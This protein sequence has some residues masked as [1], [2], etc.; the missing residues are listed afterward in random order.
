MN[1]TALFYIS[2]QT[3]ESLGREGIFTPACLT[4]LHRPTK[5]QCH[6]LLGCLKVFKKSKQS[7]EILFWMNE[8]QN[9][10]LFLTIIFSVPYLALWIVQTQVPIIKDLDIFQ[11]LPQ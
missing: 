4:I 1:N 9:N 5:Q 3:G 6:L 7:D 11:R 8:A 10:T 2:D